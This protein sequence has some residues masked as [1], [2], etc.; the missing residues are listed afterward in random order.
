MKLK[1]LSRPATYR[2]SAGEPQPARFEAV[3]AGRFRGTAQALRPVLI[4]TAF[5]LAHTDRTSSGLRSRAL[6]TALLIRRH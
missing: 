5:G 6:L 1:M 2:V 3:G 4:G